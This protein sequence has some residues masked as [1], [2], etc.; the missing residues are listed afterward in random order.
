VSNADEVLRNALTRE[1][2]PIEW[3]EPEEVRK[4]PTEDSDESRG[5]IVT[6]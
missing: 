5:G 2:T 3:T 6:H 1:P 4:L